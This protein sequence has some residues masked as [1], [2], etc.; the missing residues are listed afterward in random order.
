MM[1]LFL[2]FLLLLFYPLVRRFLRW[3]KVRKVLDLTVIVSL[4]LFFLQL[5]LL[6]VGFIPL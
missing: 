6:H 5:L 4:L 1:R 3:E 2:M